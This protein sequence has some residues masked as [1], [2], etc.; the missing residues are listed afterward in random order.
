MLRV[1]KKT[2]KPIMEGVFGRSA[3]GSEGWN[4]SPATEILP[5]PATKEDVSS[6]N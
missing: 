6:V 1:A 4:V 2:Q 3:H 5:S